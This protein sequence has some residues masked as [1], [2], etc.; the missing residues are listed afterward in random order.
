MKNSE[1]SGIINTQSKTEGCPVQW[2]LKAIAFSLQEAAI[3]NNL[4]ANNNI[5]LSRFHTLNPPKV[6]IGKYLLHLQKMSKEPKSSFIAAFILLDRLLSIQ[7][8]ITLTPNTVHKLCLCS[9]LI[10]TKFLSDK[11]L[12]NEEWAKIGGVPLEELN[13]LETEFLFMLGFSLTITKDEFQ[14]Y[15]ETFEEKAKL[16][17]F[18]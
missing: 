13:I 7:G 17:I 2:M 4:L 8:N 12:R 1:N 9:V 18:H 14:K 5:N 6:P 10:A 15:Q 3:Q 16:P 11:C